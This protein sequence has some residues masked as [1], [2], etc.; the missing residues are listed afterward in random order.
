LQVPEKFRAQ[1][2]LARA[3][4]PNVNTMVSM[5]EELRQMWL[6]THANRA[7]LADELQ[8][9][10]KRAETSGVAALRDFSMQLRTARMG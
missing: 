5:R 1:L 6:N 10:C 9:W 8:A 4:L 7:Q 3:A 2:A